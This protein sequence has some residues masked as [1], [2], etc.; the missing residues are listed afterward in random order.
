VAPPLLSVEDLHVH[1]V[2][3]R[4]VVRA[5][6]GISYDVLPGEMV[7]LV[8]ESGCGKSVSS[9]AVMRLLAKPAGRV[10]RGRIVFEG[11]D[12]LALTD[13][14]MRQI[15]GRDIAMIFQEP[16]TSLNPVLPIGFQITES[17]FMHRKIG[18][19]AARARALELL[20]MVGIPDPERRL[21]QFPHQ[22]S[23]GMRQ[24]AM[25][26]I[27][28]ACN[29]KLIIA[30]EPT[31]ALDVTIQAQILELMKELSRS[32]GIAMVMITHNLGVVAR[33]ADRV[34]VMYAA[35]IAEQAAAEALFARPLHPY[36]VGLLR[37][38]PRLDQPRGLRLETIEGLPPNLLEPPPGCRFAPR[39]AA[40]QAECERAPPPLAE[41]EPGRRSAC[42]RAGELARAG[43]QALGL[44]GRELGA[45]PPAK[46]HEAQPL[47]EARRLKTHFDVT[48]G[49]LARRRAVVKAVDDVSFAIRRGETLGLVGESGC[50]KTTIGRT[51]LRL[52][53]ATAGSVLYRDADLTRV[54]GAAL[55]PYRRKIQVIFQDPYS[56]LNPRMTVGEI[57]AEP[58]LV[59]GLQANRRAAHARAEQLLEQVGLFG[60]M[61]E[62]YPHEL[63]GGQRQRVGIA[64]ALAL[65]PEFIVCDEPVSALDVSIQAQIINLLEEL[66]RRLGLTYLFIAHDLAVVRHISDRVAVMYLG[67][68]M[69]IADRDALYSAPQHPYT[70]ALL[71][72]VP[73]PD[74]RLERERGRT[75]LGGEIPSPLEPPSGC[76]FHTRCPLADER[77]KRE[78]PALREIRPLHYAACV[79]L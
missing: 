31:T 20:R 22:F 56:S 68:V 61:A 66:Q 18:A 29:P 58:M 7:A 32:L 25:I 46:R 60:Y 49:L 35:R 4:G 67:K 1:F 75:P 13:E 72:A 21:E 16:M 59:H 27:A 74:P 38:V 45:A 57:L 63:S 33:Y 76:V 14:E 70:Q 6:E 23:G 44:A 17:L 26:A 30:D 53:E 39:C 19:E 77:C 41:I 11:R 55:Q 43:A 78:I 73:I 52:E 42:L 54:A 65:E 3:S 48:R 37:S 71:E 40:R 12:L 34:N 2:T 24:R 28:L 5:V 8:G 64:R 69:E 15:R 36:T 62:R 79:K 9:L 10:V 47:V 51:L 50:G